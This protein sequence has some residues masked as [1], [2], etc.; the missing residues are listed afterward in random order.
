MSEIDLDA[1]VAHPPKPEIYVRKRRTMPV[2]TV[3]AI[4]MLGLVVA[5]IVVPPFLGTFA[6]YKLD[7]SDALLAPFQSSRHLLGTDSLGRDILSRIS[8]G[9]QVSALIALGAV[10]I[11]C[12]LG[13]IIGLI[14]GYL[15][16][17][18]ETL[19][20][21]LSDIQLSIPIILLL[22]VIVAT[23]GSSSLTLILVL[24]LTSWVG[25][26]RV[27]RSLVVS[28]REREFVAA[29]VSAGGSALWVLRKH[30]LRAVLPQ[31]VILAAFEVGLVIT[32][33]SS[34][35]YLGLGIQP[36]TPSL[37][38]MISDGQQ[39]LQTNPALTIVPA[40]AIFLVI[41]GT[42]FLAQNARRRR[43]SGG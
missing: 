9:S 30:L 20:M 40:L 1:L 25:Y 10:A 15:R 23:V 29:A 18:V 41:G 7:I 22:I 13:T 21:G 33:E 36:P 39:Y 35:S 42:Q 12:V 4:V 24:G 19:L 14:S 38:L 27:V 43:G 34:L 26:A 16:G 2:S 5:L 17:W 31:V 3:L 11:S 6:P 32:I 28:L 37:G 8:V